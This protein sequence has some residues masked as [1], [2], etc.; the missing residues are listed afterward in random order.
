MHQASVSFVF[1]EEVI[2]GSPSAAGNGVQHQR[3]TLAR[4]GTAA[5]YHWSL[6]S[7]HFLPGTRITN[8]SCQ[9]LISLAGNI[10]FEGFNWLLN[11]LELAI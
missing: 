6:G 4:L 8:H 11:N 9:V 2:T 3:Q 10:N 5:H 1:L 7:A